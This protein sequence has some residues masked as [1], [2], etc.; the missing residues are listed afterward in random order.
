MYRFCG[1]SIHKT[2][3]LQNIKIKGVNNVNIGK[4]TFIGSET[5]LTGGNANIIIGDYC[6]ISSNVIITTGTHMIDPMGIRSAGKGYS[7][8]IIIGNG[9]WIGIGAIILPGVKIGD[10]AIVAAGS[11]VTG[12]V[13]S[14]S[15]V[16]G[17]PAKKIRDIRV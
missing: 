1:I 16:G 6:D 17:V 8:D 15:L 5:I 9:V 2:A 4:D 3:R 7:T 11:V 14:Y 12:D 13:L 10:K